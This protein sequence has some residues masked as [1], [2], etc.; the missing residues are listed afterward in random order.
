MPRLPPS[1]AG[2]AAAPKRAPRK[3]AKAPPA[4]VTALD[5]AH[6]ALDA[7]QDKKAVQISLLDVQAVSMF[8]DYFLLCNGESD[9]QITA[10]VDAV[11]DSL[12]KLGRR[13]LGL[14]GTPESGWVL[15]DFGDL[16][17]HVFTPERRTYYKLD[18]LWKDAQTVVKIQ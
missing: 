3:A 15:L 4:P 10:I 8:T 11:D 7:V 5:F 1:A 6:R 9:R 12:S 18:E 14:E 16:M 13:R 2:A 17:I